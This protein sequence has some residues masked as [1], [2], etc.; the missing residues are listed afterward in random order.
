MRHGRN[1]VFVINGTKGFGFHNL[2]GFIHWLL[3]N[4]MLTWISGEPNGFPLTTLHSQAAPGPVGGKCAMPWLLGNFKPLYKYSL[5]NSIK[6][7][8]VKRN[9]RVRII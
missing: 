9:E 6:F 8:I 4:E 5:Q 7:Q 1:F 2:L 3:G